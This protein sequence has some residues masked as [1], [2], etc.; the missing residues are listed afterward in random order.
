MQRLGVQLR[1]ASTRGVGMALLRKGERLRADLPAFFEGYTPA[2]SLLH[3]DL[4]SGNYSYCSD[5]TP[6][7]FDPAV[8]YGDREADLAMTELF[9]GFGR[10]FYDAYNE[11]WPLDPGYAQRKT[12]YN[13]YHILN[14]FNLFGGGYAD[15]AEAMIDR[16]LAEL[17]A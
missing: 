2:A 13:L 16:L 12:L 5:G 4:W 17:R 3:G 10:D 8:Y 14:H 11:T 6:V 9:G 7:L 1:I 15:Q